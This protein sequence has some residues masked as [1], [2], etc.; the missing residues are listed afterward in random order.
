MIPG[1]DNRFFD[2]F[3]PRASAHGV[4]PEFQ[5]ELIA[6]ENEQFDDNS[7]KT[8]DNI[9]IIGEIRS[10]SNGPL[11]VSL[12]VY[13]SQLYPDIETTG[14]IIRWKILS[15][16]PH[17]GIFE[18]PPRANVSYSITMKPLDPGLYHLHTQLNVINVGIVLSRGNAVNITGDSLESPELRPNIVRATAENQVTELEIHSS[19]NI[20]DFKLD[21]ESNKVSFKVAG[22]IGSRG[23]LVIPI[24]KVLGEPY[25][26]LLNGQPL[27]N[28]QT[29][30]ASNPEATFLIL[31]YLNEKSLNEFEITG[32]S[33]VPEFGSSVMFIVAAISTSGLIVTSRSSNFYRLL[34]P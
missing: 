1:L 25:L 20:S 34:K 5:S 27:T 4:A 23:S 11:Q 24:S 18:V 12:S 29:F 31:S 19:S 7:L 10:T 9:T 13:T 6:I 17:P 33:V 28:F 22:I 3:L 26:I 30:L 15:I 8:G 16:N 14:G 21:N 32:T 2:L